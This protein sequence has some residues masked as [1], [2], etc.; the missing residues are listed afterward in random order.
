MTPKAGDLVSCL[1][2]LRPGRHI[3]RIVT[4]PFEPQLHEELFPQALCGAAVWC[5]TLDPVDDSDCLKCSD[6]LRRVP[7]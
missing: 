1:S 2:E 6:A 7:R 3:R 4:R 5:D